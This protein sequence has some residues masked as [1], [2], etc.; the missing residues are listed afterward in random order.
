LVFVADGLND[1]AEAVTSTLNMSQK[2][3]YNQGRLGGRPPCVIR[4]DHG[5]VIV[6]DC[7]V[8]G[9]SQVVPQLPIWVEFAPLIRAERIVR[10]IGAVVAKRVGVSVFQTAKQQNS[11][12]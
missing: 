8:T 11:K 2:F 12:I 3:F 6:V 10:I 1:V 7:V 4:N 5:I 9:G